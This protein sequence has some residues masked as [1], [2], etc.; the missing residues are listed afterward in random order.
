MS[1]RGSF[2][3]GWW[4][5]FE[6]QCRASY[7]N[8]EIASP[9]YIKSHP[10]RGGPEPE[11]APTL[12]VSGDHFSGSKYLEGGTPTISRTFTGEGTT[13]S[14]KFEFSNCGGALDRGFEL[15]AKKSRKHKS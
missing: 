3:W 8:Y 10:Y 1:L 2:E 12:G 5:S 4:T 15:H 13:A 7:D 6:G 14:T 11:P 9:S